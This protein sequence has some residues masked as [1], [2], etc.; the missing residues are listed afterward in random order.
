MAMRKRLL[1]VLE[2]RILFSNTLT[3]V[4]VS[5][6]INPTSGA[7]SVPQFNPNLGNLEKVTLTVTGH[8][9]GGSNQAENTTAGAGLVQ[10]GIGT[11]LHVAGP[12]NTLVVLVVPNA[13][14]PN[15]PPGT[16]IGAFDGH[17]DFLGAD[18]FTLFGPNA[19]NPSVDTKSDS[20]ISPAGGG[21]DDVSVYLGTGSIAFGWD[22][23]L[24]SNQRFVGFAGNSRTTPTNFDFTATVVYQYDPQPHVIV[25]K[26]S[27]LLIDAD[28]NGVVS[29][30]DTLRYNITVTNDG[31]LDSAPIT[32]NDPM[33]DPNL[34]LVV[35]TVTTTQGV[36]LKGNSLGDSS[37]VIAVGVMTSPPATTMS[38]S[39]DAQIVNPLVVYSNSV[40]N[41]AN[42]ATSITPVFVPQSTDAASGRRR[43]GPDLPV[44]TPLL[45]ITLAPMFS[46]TAEPG[47]VLNVEM[48]GAGGL[49]LGAQ[50]VVVY[51]GGN[52]QV[53]MPDT[54]QPDSAYTVSVRQWNLFPGAGI[55]G[56]GYNL[57]TYFAP[58]FGS[59]AYAN[60]EYTV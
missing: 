8:S 26:T 2:D 37:A 9:W 12:Q 4:A 48:R 16:A 1:E 7:F 41:S 6:G 49:L 47:S 15:I 55:E 56:S 33:S 22:S 38:I 18:T 20:R 3:Y 42:G 14:S 58:A 60:E 19:N 11:S 27:S 21:V 45:P 39:L 36:V 54:V 43:R 24:F 5:A 32:I 50:S 29:P 31:G 52:W 13:Q 25:T 10:L 59:L 34:R 28:H 44:T 23:S 40:V 30:G 35:G 17:A 53:S 46:G 51:A 57:R